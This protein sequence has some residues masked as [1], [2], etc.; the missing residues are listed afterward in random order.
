MAFRDRDSGSS[1]RPGTGAQIVSQTNWKNVQ[2][3]NKGQISD[4]LR[5]QFQ[6]RVD[7]T[8]QEV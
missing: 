6:R 8:V 5:S 3:C 4:L 7:D 1:G 2:K